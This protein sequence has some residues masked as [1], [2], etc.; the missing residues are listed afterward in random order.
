MNNRDLAQEY[1]L[2]RKWHVEINPNGAELRR[3]GVPGF[4][5]WKAARRFHE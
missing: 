4:H 2:T 3:I 1:R 5:T